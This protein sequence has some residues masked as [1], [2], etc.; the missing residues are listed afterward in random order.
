MHSYSVLGIF[1]TTFLE[2]KVTLLQIRNPLGYF[3]K[4]IPPDLR[5]NNKDS[6]WETI[7]NE[8]KDRLEYWRIE[9]AQGQGI[10]YVEW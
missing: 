1:E 8:E 10:F 2:T 9:R 3:A 7:T 4:N 6:F 5:F